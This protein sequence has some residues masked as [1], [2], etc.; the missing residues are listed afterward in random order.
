MH[1][2]CLGKVP[3]IFSEGVYNLVQ[4]YVRFLQVFS[5]L[6]SGLWGPQKRVIL[7]MTNKVIQKSVTFYKLAQNK[8]FKTLKSA[9]IPS[10]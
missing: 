8:Q 1:V 9:V 7:N 4:L 5:G 3:G 2:T 10:L 6:K